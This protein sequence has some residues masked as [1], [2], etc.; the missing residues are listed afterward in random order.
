MVLVVSKNSIAK[1]KLSS[2]ETDVVESFEAL[3]SVAR[4]VLKE[5][6]QDNLHESNVNE[7][8]KG[9]L[10][11]LYIN[12]FYSSRTGNTSKIIATSSKHL[13]RPS[14]R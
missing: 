13:L 6:H 4:R 7:D 3:E 12:I 14:G 8:V 11:W 2:L 10:R 9:T 5:E 1:Q